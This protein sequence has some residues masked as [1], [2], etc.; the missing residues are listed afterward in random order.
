MALSPFECP[1]SY[2]DFSFHVDIRVKMCQ[3]S[4]KDVIYTTY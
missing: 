2:L 4:I 3:V 1:P